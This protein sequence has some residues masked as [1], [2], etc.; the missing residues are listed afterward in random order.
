[1]N[2]EAAVDERPGF[3]IKAAI[4]LSDEYAADCVRAFESRTMQID[5]NR[6]LHDCEPV[7]FAD[8][9]KTDYIVMRL[10]CVFI[11]PVS[12]S[13]A[14]IE[15]SGKDHLQNSRVDS[16][17]VSSELID[18][19]TFVKLGNAMIVNRHHP[20]TQKLGAYLGAFEI[21]RD[22]WFSCL[23]RQPDKQS[24]KM[25]YYAFYVYRAT[26]AISERLP[27]SF[28]LF[29]N[30]SND[31]FKGFWSYRDALQKLP[32]KGLEVDYLV[33]KKVLNE[34]FSSDDIYE[35]PRP[36][37]TK[38]AEVNQPPPGVPPSEWAIVTA[39][40]GIPD[41]DLIEDFSS[42][43]SSLTKPQIEEVF[44]DWQARGWVCC[45]PKEKSPAKPLDR[46]VFKTDIKVIEE[47]LAVQRH[48]T[49]QN[50]NVNFHG[51]V[52][53]NVGVAG[54]T[55]EGDVTGTIS[56]GDGLLPAIQALIA[57]LKSEKGP[58]A[59]AAAAD[60]D[61]AIKKTSAFE[62]AKDLEQATK[63]PGVF[64]RLKELA[65]ALSGHAVAG[66]L[67]EGI[68]LYLVSKGV[69]LH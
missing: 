2:R 64:D 55:A 69:L 13:V 11:D 59:A 56:T 38:E 63:H 50:V 19:Y 31:T 3:N 16:L 18:T 51:Q 24:G 22:Y 25:R 54:G 36:I 49:A 52:I 17:L 40:K 48:N 62:V 65:L 47:R 60:L 20:F 68:K 4:H 53:G 57:E 34:E 66:V 10:S 28:K 6:L 26:L 30:V 32:S 27:K 67:W 1:M 33:A 12:N 61:A 8:R 21:E 9:P 23:R 37:K 35:E 5:Y 14:V 41:L 7:N 15:R 58:S 46:V 42:I 43:S 39:L 29:G 44:Y 45:H